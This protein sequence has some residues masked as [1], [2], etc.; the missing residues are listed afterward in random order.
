MKINMVSN[1]NHSAKSFA[2]K[3]PVQQIPDD[4]IA[5][6]IEPDEEA[7]A[8]TAKILELVGL[9]DLEVHLDVVPV[10][11]DMFRVHGT[12]TAS[13]TQNC[14][15][16]LDPVISKV[17]EPIDVE[18]R[19]KTVPGSHNAAQF[20]N[21]QDE[22]PLDQKDIEDYEA[23]ALELG[24]L[25]SEILASAINPYPRKPGVDFAWTSDSA[26]DPINKI[27]SEESPF[28]RLSSIKNDA[29][30]SETEGG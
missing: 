2:Y 23:G 20:P 14:V 12:L 24:A 10:S 9:Q 30:R 4:G 3:L 16:S 1:G 7:C 15:V 25:V 26:A 29:G 22:D 19:P 21:E 13:V 28:A 11:E 8:E 18:F 5:V 27:A 6:R 17:L